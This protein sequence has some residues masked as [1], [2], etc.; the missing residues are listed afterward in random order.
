M[1]GVEDKG[2]LVKNYINLINLDRFHSTVLTLYSFAAGGICVFFVWQVDLAKDAKISAVDQSSVGEGP[3]STPYVRIT[4]SLAL[5]ANAYL[6]SQRPVEGW[7]RLLG[8]SAL[9]SI[10]YVI[11]VFKS[12]GEA[13]ST[14]RG[15]N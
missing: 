3:F 14:S 15:I 12:A 7:I 2:W 5:S 13:S 1:L 11:S 10:G 4:A 9:V 6:L 8:I